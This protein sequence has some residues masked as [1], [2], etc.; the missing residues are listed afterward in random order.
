[1]SPIA[2]CLRLTAA[3][4]PQHPSHEGSVT[5][6]VI[7]CAAAPTTLPAASDAVDPSGAT[8]STRRR[9]PLADIANARQSGSQP[10]PTVQSP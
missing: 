6:R 2:A 4:S 1:M 7:A 5:L 8:R 9:R 10:E 3:R